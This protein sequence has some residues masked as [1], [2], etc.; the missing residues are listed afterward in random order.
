MDSKPIRVVWGTPAVPGGRWHAGVLNL[1]TVPRSDPDSISQSEAL[2]ASLQDYSR[3]HP[4]F[5][6]R[7]V[8]LWVLT[9]AILGYLGGTAV[10]ARRIQASSPHNQ[11]GYL[12]VLLPWRWDGISRLRGEAMIAQA[13]DSLQAGRFQDGF[14]ELRGGLARH[15]ADHVARLELARIYLQMRLLPHSVV[16]LRAGL[17]YG[18]PGRPL[19]ET[20][21]ALLRE[22]DQPEILAQTCLRARET[23][24]AVAEGERPVGDDRWLDQHTAL[25]LVAVGRGDE[26]YALVEKAYPPTDTFR[27]EFTLAR[28]LDGNQLVEARAYAERWAGESPQTP[29]PH[30]LLAVATRRLGD[31]PAMETALQRLYAITPDQPEPLLFAL[32]QNQLAGRPDAVRATFDRLILRHGADPELYPVAANLVAEIGYRPGLDQLE[33][34]A[35]ERGMALD[36]MLWTRLELAQQDRDWTAVRRIAADLKN[37][38]ASANLSPVRRA[39]LTN[40]QLLAEA[41]IEGASGTQTMLVNSI[42]A[43]PGSLKLYVRVLEALLE[44]GRLGT[45]R[46]VLVLAE[47]PFPDSRALQTLRARLEKALVES[48]PVAAETPELS[49]ALASFA[50]FTD[51]FAAR[52][53]AADDA[54]ALTL[55]REARRAAPDW[56]AAEVTRVEALELPVLARGDDP[57][58]LQLLVR[59]ALARNARAGSELLTLARQIHPSGHS[60]LIVKEI[61][62][63]NPADDDAF[64]QLREW[65]PPPPEAEKAP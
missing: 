41:C 50:A 40:S 20:L 37:S 33:R 51:A 47:G 54:G 60:V 12:D 2:A 59:S 22:S 53:G 38:L 64:V 14:G 11:V 49:P 17:D 35:A 63:H 15:P 32:T 61:L 58:R 52:A 6:L 56:F 36:P 18:Y 65:S 26:A 5:S 34:E 55:L 19:L 28:L 1:R 62:R 48:A 46:E 45:A 13:H 27:R 9:L 57:L 24:S 30:S 16:L 31:L 10:V 39:W 7:G 21:F 3:H 25:S 23:L 43:N 42:A 29:A 8:V 4:H 44:A